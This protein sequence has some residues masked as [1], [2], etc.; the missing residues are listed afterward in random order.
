M[1]ILGSMSMV[2]GSDDISLATATKIIIIE[3]FANPTVFMGKFPYFGRRVTYYIIPE[4]NISY[5]LADGI[6]GI[7]VHLA[8]VGTLEDTLPIFIPLHTFDDRLTKVRLHG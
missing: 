7:H 4:Y 8:N 1:E 2:N 3:L 5:N 6:S